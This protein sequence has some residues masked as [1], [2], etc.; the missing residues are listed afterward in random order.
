MEKTVSTNT[1]E[2]QENTEALPDIPCA[3]KLVKRIKD[4]LY[5][6]GKQFRES[7]PDVVRRVSDLLA[8]VHCGR[9]IYVE[10]RHREFNIDEVKEC[11]A[12]L[13]Y[14]V[15]PAHPMVMNPYGA[16]RI[17]WWPD[18]KPNPYLG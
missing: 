8:N 1:M 5:T 16:F 7:H 10:N 15:K 12:G 9:D 2:S 6:R 17:V 4:D 3:E 13:G 14:E 11:L 18:D